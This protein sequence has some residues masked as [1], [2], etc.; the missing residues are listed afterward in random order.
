MMLPP[1][2]AMFLICGDAV[3]DDG[4]AAPMVSGSVVNT[5]S[6][7]IRSGEGGLPEQLK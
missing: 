7:A 6:S 3:S 4:H 1:T 5:F 2:V